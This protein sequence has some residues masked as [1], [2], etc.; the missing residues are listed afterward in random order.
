M[1]KI[2]SS[3]EEM[4]QDIGKTCAKALKNGYV[5]ALDGDLGAG[6]TVFTRGIAAGLKIKGNI[7]SPTFT[8]LR[9]YEGENFKFNHLDLYRINDADELYEIGI[10]DIL[11]DGITVIEWAKKASGIFRNDAL[12]ISIARGKKED[13]REISFYCKDILREKEFFEVLKDVYTCD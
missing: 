3:S 2:T 11:D 10:L 7:L 4:T 13:D 5:I 12:F 8:I 1:F 6:K 9:Q